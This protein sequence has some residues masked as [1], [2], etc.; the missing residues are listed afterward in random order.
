M[1]STDYA[2]ISPQSTK[3]E[4]SRLLTAGIVLAL[5]LGIAAVVINVVAW[6]RPE[7]PKKSTVPTT[8]AVPH[9]PVD[10][11]A[12]SRDLCS[13]IA[14]LMAENDAFANAYAHLGEPGTPARDA[15][16]P[17]FVID[18]KDWIS[19]IQPIVDENPD[20]DPYLRRTLQRFIDDQHLIMLELRPGQLTS[21][22]QALW[23]D[24]LGA[25]AGPLLHCKN[26]NVIW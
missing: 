15:A 24:S 4:R 2:Y 19:R 3:Q 22:W 13:A 6:T 11:Q 12:A 20:A 23:S 18:T 21:W 10:S 5:I 25:Y 17:K 26:L 1:N 9:P 8:A 14:P 16:T 7:P